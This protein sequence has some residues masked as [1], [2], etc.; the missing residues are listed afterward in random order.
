MVGDH[1][2]HR[3]DL[4]ALIPIAPPA[5]ILARG[6]AFVAVKACELGW[7]FAHDC[8]LSGKHCGSQTEMAKRIGLIW[9]ECLWQSRS[10]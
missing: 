4:N 9:L 8:V 1:I 3:S 6:A 5:G 10:W 2:R 7:A